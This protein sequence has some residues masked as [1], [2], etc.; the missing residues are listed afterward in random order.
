[1]LRRAH[2]ASIRRRSF[3]DYNSKAVV[4]AGVRPSTTRAS[5][6]CSGLTIGDVSVQVSVRKTSHSLS[7]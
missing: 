1:M 6:L 3:A 2:G 4:N 7:F 5:K